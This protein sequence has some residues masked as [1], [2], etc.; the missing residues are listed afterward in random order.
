MKLCYIFLLLGIYISCSLDNAASAQTG[1]Y[2]LSSPGVGGFENA[3]ASVSVL[4]LI[5]TTPTGGKWTR[6]FIS[7]SFA[8]TTVSA[9]DT[10]RSGTKA[11]RVNYNLSSSRVIYSPLTHIKPPSNSPVTIQYFQRATK[12][13]DSIQPFVKLNATTNTGAYT[14]VA[15]VNS[16]EKKY[17]TTTVNSPGSGNATNYYGAFNIKK[18]GVTAGNYYFDDVCIYSGAYDVTPPAAV[19]ALSIQPFDNFDP[20]INATNAT[21]LQWTAPAGGIDGG[22]YMIVQ[23]ATEPNNDNI[24]NDN[25][26]YGIGN[27]M[28]NGIGN[29]PGKVVVVNNS[30]SVNAVTSGLIQFLQPGTTYWFKVYT[31]D[32]A[33]NY[34]PAAVIS[35]TTKDFATYYPKPTGALNQTTTWGKNPDGSGDSPA[36]FSS[37]F[38]TFNVLRNS[39]IDGDWSFSG[40]LSRIIVGNGV[41]AVEFVIP[42]AYNVTRPENDFTSEMILNKNVT[43]RILNSNTAAMIPLTADPKSILEF[44]SEANQIINTSNCG[45]LILSGGGIKTPLDNPVVNGDLVIKDNVK[46]EEGFYFQLMGNCIVDDIAPIDPDEIKNAGINLFYDGGAG[47]VHTITDNGWGQAIFK[48]IGIWGGSIARLNSNLE[49]KGRLHLNDGTLELGNHT[50]T[51]DGR[52][53]GS[54]V[55]ALT[56]SKQSNVVIGSNYNSA[57]TLYFKQNTSANYLNSLTLNSDATLGNKLRIAPSTMT[58]G[59]GYLRVVGG[60]LHT[61]TEEGG[62]LVLTSD[63]SGTARIAESDGEYL[64]GNVTLQQYIPARRA[65]RLVTA[66]VTMDDNNTINSAWQNGQVYNSLTGKNYPIDYNTNDYTN[67]APISTPGIGTHITKGTSTAADRDAST[68]MTRGFDYGVNTPGATASLRIFKDGNFN[69]S[70][71]D[72][73]NTYDEFLKEQPAYLLFIRGDRNIDLADNNATSS[74]TLQY[75]AK[76]ATGGADLITAVPSMQVDKPALFGNPYPSPIDFS[77]LKI[78]NNNLI[79]DKFYVFDSRLG[80][81]GGYRVVQN[82]GSYES[83][84]YDETLLNHE[85]DARHIQSSQGFFVIPTAT[86]STLTTNEGTKSDFTNPQVYGRQLAKMYISMYQRSANDSVNLTDGVMAGFDQSFASQ[87]DNNDASKFANFNENF[88][89]RRDGKRLFIETRPEIKAD[90]TLFF[91]FTNMVVRNYQFKIKAANFGGK[92]LTAYLVDK[93]LNTNT[94]LGLDGTTTSINFAVTSNAASKSDTRFMIIFKPNIILP[95]TLTSVKAYRKNTDVEVEWIVNNETEVN[96]YEVEKSL[97]GSVFSATSNTKARNNN[98]NNEVYNWLDTKPVDGYNYYRIKTISK[99]GTVKY[100]SIVRVLMGRSNNT[101]ITFFPNPVVGNRVGL[102]LNNMDKGTYLIELYNQLGQKVYNQ[103][104]QHNGGSTSQV[105]QLSEK[106][107]KGVYQMKIS[108]AATMLFKVVFQ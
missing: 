5:K 86:A 54:A 4:D 43:L 23:Y 45:T 33:F 67:A 85:D 13:T 105:L 41:D 17:F 42:E 96:Y 93:F 100:S 21:Q 11:L 25:G 88:Y 71:A 20:N 3:P 52:F 72:D 78:A 57:D 48:E 40:F 90:D 62:E 2:L 53:N 1:T 84:P 38:Q 32:K 94:P 10:V 64:D 46:I 12:Q 51:L 37:G 31:F 18:A 107:P 35:Y 98:A 79:Q 60:T 19:N 83:L 27:V 75:S 49:I 91:G 106:I 95:V 81:Y 26:V 63:A 9:T 102:Q 92:S 29:L 28:T 15:A 68:V 55:N 87:V 6:S 97:D 8:F 77:R 66:P 82:V 103:S 44:G 39:T 16:W 70:L 14:S 74:T 22:G 30:S 104:L 58:V 36:D 56:G 50:L 65:W 101:G 59:T 108:G 80:T 34:S 73:K 99:T 61:N 7:S 89:L 76:I 69:S 24:P 47:H